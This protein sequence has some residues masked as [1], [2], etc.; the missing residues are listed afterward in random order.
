MQN[1]GHCLF[2]LWKLVNFVFDCEK[3]STNLEPYGER[4]TCVAVESVLHEHDLFANG[5]E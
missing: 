3:K 4:L 2:A 1:N 5:S